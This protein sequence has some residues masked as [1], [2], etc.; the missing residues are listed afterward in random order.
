MNIQEI[1]YIRT[2][3]RM[4]VLYIHAYIYIRTI[5]THSTSLGNSES[6]HNTVYVHVRTSCTYSTMYI[7]YGSAH[8]VLHTYVHTT[9]TFIQV[10]MHN[11]STHTNSMDV[12][13]CVHMLL[14][15][16]LP[17]RAA[18]FTPLSSAT[19]SW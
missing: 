8:T 15:T 13:A 17:C 1:K 9:Y 12:H 11:K 7:L 10:R 2:Y 19:I 6:I 16:I 14:C 5:S 4:H 18:S 3:V